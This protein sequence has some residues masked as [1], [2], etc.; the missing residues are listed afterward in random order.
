M[1][2]KMNIPF[3][4]QH[5]RKTAFRNKRILLIICI[6]LFFTT[7]CTGCQLVKKDANSTNNTLQLAKEN[8]AS[9]NDKLIGIYVTTEYID[10]SDNK[11]Y[12]TLDNENQTISFPDI[13][14]YALLYPSFEKDGET[15]NYCVNKAFSNINILLTD[16]GLEVSGT[17]YYDTSKIALLQP[18]DSPEEELSFFVHP[19]YEA[20]DGKVYL[21]LSTDS[22]IFVSDENGKTSHTISG[23]RTRTIDGQSD[24][25]QT[26]FTTS[27]EA[28]VPVIT[29]V[30]TQMD[31]TG[32]ILQ[33]DT[34]ST[35]DIPES[36]KRNP[37][38]A[39]ILV[40]STDQN[41]TVTYD[42]INNEEEGY[43]F[44]IPTSSL[45]CEEAYIEIEN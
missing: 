31:Q 17:L 44:Y 25:I 40:T 5:N 9:S 19:V 35:A 36:Y 30:F 28:T 15:Y 20:T 1:N 11:I 13:E 12:G 38:S 4:K 16:E 6:S 18:C 29:I 7:A 10:N 34:Y 8:M 37:D 27:Y 14:G 41:G 45:I 26:K 2:H 43:S 33:S 3:Y 23:T 42:V 39:Y 22:G 24:N 32:N 21:I